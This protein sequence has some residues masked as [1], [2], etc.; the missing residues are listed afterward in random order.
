MAATQAPRYRLRH[1]LDEAEA[2]REAT[3]NIGFE[4]FR[5]SWV[6]R[7]AVEHGLLIIA[8]ASNTLPAELKETQP[9]IPWAQIVSFG[10]LL[11]HEYRDVDP[12]IV[13]RIVHEDL[14]KLTV[15]AEQMLAK[16][17]R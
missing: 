14:P 10:N 2:I 5:D 13:W 8:E 12:A 3:H 17:A 7:R 16:L 6:I 11:R 9:T 4:Q 1:I 15:A